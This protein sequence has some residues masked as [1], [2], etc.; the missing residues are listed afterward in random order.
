MILKKKYYILLFLITLFITPIVSAQELGKAQVP[1][2]FKE[3][4]LEE[5]FILDLKSLIEKSKKKIE[6]VDEKIKEQ[7]VYRRNLQRE[8]KARGLYQQALRLF[9]EEKYDKA[10]EIWE[11]AIVITGHPEM[12]DYMRTSVKRTKKKIKAMKKAEEVRIQQLEEDRGYT[13]KQVEKEYQTAIS[14]YKKGQYLESRKRFEQVEKMFLDHKGTRSYLKLIDMHIQE[15]Q[16]RLIAQK[17]KEKATERKKKKAE[18]RTT[19]ANQE[20]EKSIEKKEKAANLYTEAIKLYKIQQYGSAKEKFKEIEWLLPNYRST[21]KYLIKVKKAIRKEEER[22]KN[23]KERIIDERLE[24][25]VN[26][27]FEEQQKIRSSAR[28]KLDKEKRLK[29]E[30][31]FIYKAALNL[32]NQKDYIG[33]H[34]KFKEVHEIYPFYKKTNKYIKK[35]AKKI[36]AIQRK[37]V[38]Q[39]KADQEEPKKMESMDVRGENT[40]LTPMQMQALSLAY[41]SAVSLYESK[42]YEMASARFE[43]IRGINPSYKKTALYLEKIDKILNK[44]KVIKPRSKKDLVRQK[45]KELNPVYQEGI[46]LFEQR[47]YLASKSLFEQVQK[48]IPNYKQT[49]KY[50]HDIKQAQYDDVEGFLNQTGLSTLPYNDKIVYEIRERRKQL[51]EQSEVKYKTAL[52]LYH[53]NKYQQSKQKFIELEAFYPGYKDVLMHLAK[54]DDEIARAVVPPDRKLEKIRI[55]NTQW[56]PEV[57]QRKIQVEQI[58]N[59]GS[60]RVENIYSEARA[61]YKRKQYE[62]AFSKFLE[63]NQLQQGYK[64]V[65]PYMKKTERMIERLQLKKDRQQ[66]K[67]QARLVKLKKFEAKKPGS[68]AAAEKKRLADIKAQ[69]E[70]A[71]KLAQEE[72]QLARDKIKEALRLEKIKKKK[73][74][75]KERQNTIAQKKQEKEQR[76]ME[77]L[78]KKELKK[79]KKSQNLAKRL[80]EKESRRL[81][82]LREKEE[83]EKKAA[84]L[85]LQKELS[86]KNRLQDELKRQAEKEQA[87]SQKERDQLR[88]KRLK[89]KQDNLKA[90]QEAKAR[91][92]LEKEQKR[93]EKRAQKQFKADQ[94]EKNRYGT[95]YNSQEDEQQLSKRARK[96]QTGIKKDQGQV[97]RHKQKVVSKQQ[98][99]IYKLLELERKTEKIDWK[100]QTHALYKEALK[101]YKEG[102]YVAAKMKFLSVEG[103]HP[104]YKRAQS[105]L[106]KVDEKIALQRTHYYSG[107]D[108]NKKDYE[109]NQKM[110]VKRMEGDAAVNSKEEKDRYESWLN[111]EKHLNQLEIDEETRFEERRKE[112]QLAEKKVSREE[113]RLKKIKDRSERYRKAKEAGRIKEKINLIYTE[114]FALYNDEKYDL[115]EDQFFQMDRLLTRDVFGQAYV[116]KMQK[117]IQHKKEESKKRIERR[118]QKRM[119]ALRRKEEKEL[120]AF[121]E[122]EQERLDKL[123]ELEQK[124]K[125]DEVRLKKERESFK[126]ELSRKKIETQQDLLAEFID[127]QY[128][129][130]ERVLKQ[131][132]EHKKKAL[133]QR[134]QEINTRM[135]VVDSGGEVVRK[136]RRQSQAQAKRSNRE[137]ESKVRSFYQKAV[138]EY[139][140][141]SYLKARKMFLDIQKLYP[142]YK[143]TGKYLHKIERLIDNKN[144]KT[145]SQRKKYFQIYNQGDTSR[146]PKTSREHSISAA[147]DVIEHKM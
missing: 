6:K 136:N 85:A 127:N 51:V 133:D 35:L 145:V 141:G 87:Q 27:R 131:K 13:F 90:K 67:E 111:K 142:G 71:L 58:V 30:A 56:E 80:A 29:E 122:I 69:E 62:E 73:L 114:A 20:K 77:A 121:R 15:E 137:F 68:H 31:D 98:K 93:E 9:E 46:K 23:H 94:K 143:G 74:A 65:K 75:Q 76:R 96:V 45:K 105:Y 43:D 47:Q 88:L 82:K 44:K 97:D 123:K 134:Y 108:K 144:K 119:E 60:N 37:K 5:G 16:K 36:V 107:Y 99:Q 55:D 135:K 14:L 104:G 53:T 61:L 38:D 124:I 26:L 117:K 129:A 33:A 34:N 12:K 41:D 81:E 32:Y 112:E 115:A 3:Q 52:A 8:E 79:N 78:K 130:E 4:K 1:Q 146:Q 139:K 92:K 24:E 83:K 19:I 17:L 84:Q 40:E 70:E 11:K 109:F 72:E 95:V 113:K 39:E 110:L 103:M 106:D 100:K 126:L 86:E 138:K 125:E 18:W 49:K 50:L 89:E 64:S 91:R 63:V 48:T 59:D 102:N 57:F 147:L 21:R 140:I 128:S 120:L 28:K 66:A 22:K 118:K 54:I 42:H 2:P 25:V 7:A 132:I 101:L 116:K 10:G